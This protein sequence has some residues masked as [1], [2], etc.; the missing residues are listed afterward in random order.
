M[1]RR[2]L[3]RDGVPPVFVASDILNHLPHMFSAVGVEVPPWCQLS[4]LLWLFFFFFLIPYHLPICHQRF[5][6]VALAFWSGNDLIVFVIT[7][8][9][10]QLPF[11]DITEDVYSSRLILFRWVAASF[12][13]CCCSFTCPHFKCFKP[14]HQPWVGMHIALFVSIEGATHIFSFLQQRILSMNTYKKQYSCC[15]DSFNQYQCDPVVSN[16]KQT[17]L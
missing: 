12:H 14:P 13:I 1:R 9:S 16:I 2:G 15:V 4:V 17:N 5:F 6:A 7:A 11:H 3:T 10:T 8:S